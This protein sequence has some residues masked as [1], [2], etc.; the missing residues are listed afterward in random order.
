MSQMVHSVLKQHPMGKTISLEMKRCQNLKL[1]YKLVVNLA[2]PPSVRANLWFMSA[3]TSANFTRNLLNLDIADTCFVKQ[4]IYDCCY[5]EIRKGWNV[6][7][8]TLSLCIIYQKTPYITHSVYQL[9]VDGPDTPDGRVTYLFDEYRDL[10][11][12]RLDNSI[13]Y[14]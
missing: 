14:K 9:T 8:Y 4:T 2:R 11:H 5:F 3:Y 10:L 13:Y 7:C 1:L 12:I 6:S